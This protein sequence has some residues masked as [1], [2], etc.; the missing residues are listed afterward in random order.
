[1]KKFV[2][3]LHVRFKD[4]TE[5]AVAEVIQEAADQEDARRMTPHH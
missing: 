2:S 4:A 3:V 1:M 5:A